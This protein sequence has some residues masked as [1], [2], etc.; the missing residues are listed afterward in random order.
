MSQVRRSRVSTVP[1]ARRTDQGTRTHPTTGV[2]AGA[3]VARSCHRTVPLAES[4]R[5]WTPYQFQVSRSAMSPAFCPPAVGFVE[6]FIVALKSPT[7]RSQSTLPVNVAP[8]MSTPVVETTW[9]WPGVV[10][11]TSCA[12]GGLIQVHF[13]S[14]DPP[15]N[16]S[17]T[18]DR[19]EAFHE[20]DCH[21]AIVPGPRT[22]AIYTH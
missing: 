20:I 14:S 16:S 4:Y 18:S 21:C 8:P 2:G 9:R 1:A 15:L 19:A 6:N 11:P 3:A 12:A 7:I 5:F 17:A 10:A 13:G 22:V